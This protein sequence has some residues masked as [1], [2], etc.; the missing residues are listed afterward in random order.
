MPSWLSSTVRYV[1]EEGNGE[2][3]SGKEQSATLQ[4]ELFMVRQDGSTKEKSIDTCIIIMNN[5]EET[6]NCGFFNEKSRSISSPVK[7]RHPGLF[8]GKMVKNTKKMPEKSVD[9]EGMSQILKEC[10][11]NVGLQTF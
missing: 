6:V 10:R 2:N 9:L 3:Y 7:S 8:E 5:T 1:G 11:K 4:N